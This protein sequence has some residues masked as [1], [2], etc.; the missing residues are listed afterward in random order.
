MAHEEDTKFT[1]KHCEAL[2]DTIAHDRDVPKECK[3]YSAV[4]AVL[5]KR[6]SNRSDDAIA[7]E[8]MHPGEALAAKAARERGHLNPSQIQRRMTNRNSKR[9][10]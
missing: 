3:E 6:D 1:R 8:G 5:L 10:W 9:V 4:L 7:F 2:L